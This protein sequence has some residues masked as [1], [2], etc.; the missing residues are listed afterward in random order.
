MQADFKERMR[1]WSYWTLV[2]L[3]LFMGV[4]G[5]PNR[6]S[7]F[8]V[9]TID[10]KIYRQASNPTWIP[11]SV[12]LVLG[13]FLP[14]IE[15]IYLKNMLIVDQKNGAAEL[16]STIQFSKVKYILGKLLSACLLMLSLLIFII[17]GSF[18]M[19]LLRFPGQNFSWQQFLMPF[20]LMIPGI[21]LIAI[22]AIFSETVSFLRGT[23]G[24]ILISV[25]ILIS[26]IW[27]TTDPA[28]FIVRIGNFSGNVYLIET[29]RK[30]CIAASGKSFTSLGVLSSTIKSTGTRDLIFPA[31]SFSKQNVAVFICQ[32]LLLL[33]FFLMTVI[34]FTPHHYQNKVKKSAT[35][36]KKVKQPVSNKAIRP[37]PLLKLS[38]INLW[39]PMSYWVKLGILI[40]WLL[41]LGSDRQ[42]CVQF[43]LPLILLVALPFLSNIGVQGQKMGMN[44]WLKTINN[45]R[46]KQALFECLAGFFSTLLLLFP[47][48]IKSGKG[49]FL[50]VSFTF[51][52]VLFAW[53]LG[54]MTG[55]NRLFVFFMVVFWFI[56]LNGATLF[57]PILGRNIL[58]VGLVYFVAAL[59][60]ACLQR[61]ML[62]DR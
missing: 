15:Y 41:A 36:Y 44:V 1:R 61:I 40:L 19:I 45:S 39:L 3:A 35:S 14:I 30:A 33:I 50:L 18:A 9:F 57:L 24:T 13:L 17:I 38:F 31:I 34:F 54:K 23:L 42:T 22:L 51:F 37:V 11:I 60:I 56:Y 43:L 12:C 48:I 25:L 10:P 47:I 16:M 4:I 59:S 52:L 46:R 21:V 20:L 6:N 32:L 53:L 7:S 27:G 28:N 29:I 49:A 62:K 55:D 5:S 8:S 26:Y 2:L 58:L